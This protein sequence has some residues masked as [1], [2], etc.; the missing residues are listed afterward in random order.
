[1][2]VATSL[3]RA[4]VRLD[5]LVAQCR[6]AIHARSRAARAIEDDRERT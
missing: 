1:M 4:M 5:I 2:H 3:D 6:G